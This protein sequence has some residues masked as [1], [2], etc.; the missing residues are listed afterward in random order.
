[1]TIR[2]VLFDLDETLL[3]RSGSL[4]EFLGDQHA[5][6]GHRLGNV[7]LERWR[8]RFIALDD[9]GRVSKSDVYPRILDAFGGDAACA[10]DLLADYQVNCCRHA[11]PNP[12]M[13]ETLRSLRVGG[14]AL[15]IVTNGQTDLQTRHI[16]ALQ[17][18]PLVDTILISEAEGLRKPDPALFHRAADRLG[19][20]PTECLFV[21]DDPVSDILGA[22]KAGMRAAWLHGGRE[23]PKS[24][25][26]IPGA[27]IDRLSQVLQ[28][29]EP[30]GAR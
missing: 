24:A 1:M 6:F 14:L 13:G 19:M 3:D 2:A 10:P 18:A 27:T 12:G 26:P 22:H 17:L 7:S 9:R 25:A 11:R 23:W 16:D 20:N 29:I 5:R 21:G 15:G 28:L 30:A 4:I 8:E